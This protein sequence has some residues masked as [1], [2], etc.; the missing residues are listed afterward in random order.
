MTRKT[1]R[2]QTSD[3]IPYPRVRFEAVMLDLLNGNHITQT[4]PDDPGLYREPTDHD[5]KDDPEA[6]F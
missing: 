4:E 6:D 5:E 1:I 3:G 2:R